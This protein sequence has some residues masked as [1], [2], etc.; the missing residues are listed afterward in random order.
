MHIFSN[1]VDLDDFEGTEIANILSNDK[2]H[3]NIIICV[4]PYYQENSRG[5]RITEF[6]K[7]L[8]GY[9][10]AYRFE[11]HTDEWDKNSSCQ[12]HIYVSSYY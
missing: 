3:N 7:M 10:L 5:K 6:G 1:V 2:S 11:K 4:S 9:N 8:K 12:I